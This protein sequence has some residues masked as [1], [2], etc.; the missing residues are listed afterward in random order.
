MPLWVGAGFR[1]Q[2]IKLSFSLRGRGLNCEV[3]PSPLK[4]PHPYNALRG[5]T[6]C[7]FILHA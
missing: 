6:A 2:K 7:D 1:V 3:A 5:G 4:I